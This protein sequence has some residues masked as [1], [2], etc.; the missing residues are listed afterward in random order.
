MLALLQQT[1][2]TRVVESAG[3]VLAR[4][5]T[6]WFAVLVGLAAL[7]ALRRIPMIDGKMNPGTPR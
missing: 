3:T 6:L 1:G 4:L 7:L 5:V 2:V